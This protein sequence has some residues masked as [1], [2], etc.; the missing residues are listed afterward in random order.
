MATLTRHAAMDGLHVGL[1]RSVLARRYSASYLQALD[2]AGTNG[3]PVARRVSQGGPRA[4]LRPVWL[5]M[6]VS[7]PRLAPA[8]V[9]AIRWGASRTQVRRPDP[10]SASGLYGWTDVFEGWY[11]SALSP[12]WSADDTGDE[13]DPPDSG[14][15]P[16][17]AVSENVRYG[18]PQGGRDCS[19]RC[20][21]AGWIGHS[22]VWG[23]SC[24][25]KSRWTGGDR[26]ETIYWPCGEVA[27]FL[28]NYV[29][30]EFVLDTYFPVQPYW[31]AAP[32]DPYEETGWPATSPGEGIWAIP[33]R[34]TL[35][36]GVWSRSSAGQP[37]SGYYEY[38]ATATGWLHSAAAFHRFGPSARTFVLQPGY[39]VET[40]AR[41]TGDEGMPEQAAADIRQSLESALVNFTAT[42]EVRKHGNPFA[43]QQQ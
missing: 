16:V 28:D 32:S 1:A 3:L 37:Y 35:K 39:T 38:S 31:G 30:A 43:R 20:E 14:G 22:T 10:C 9:P 34:A 36:S 18:A 33:F 5:D 26:A 13:I 15:S 6:R 11:Y 19:D 7:F 2:E 4:L 42:V 12:V 29:A 8:T 23:A 21:I 25:Q 24:R 17:A 40:T 41:D 27:D